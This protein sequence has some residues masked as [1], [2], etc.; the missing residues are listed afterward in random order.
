MIK[1]NDKILK[2]INKDCQVPEDY[3]Q[4]IEDRVLGTYH[5]RQRIRRRKVLLSVSCVLVLAIMG[6]FYAKY[7]STLLKIDTINQLASLTPTTTPP[8]EMIINEE[9]AKVEVNKVEKEKTIT[10]T[11]IKKKATDSYSKKEEVRYTEKE[12]NYLENYL[13]EDTYEL[14]YN[15]LIK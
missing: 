8:N 1:D 4:N 9:I 7:D 15:S 6:V 14:V 3:F 13:N 12:L 5:K 2:P 10:N 11:P